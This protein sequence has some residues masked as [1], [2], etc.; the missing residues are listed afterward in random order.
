[1][2]R[3]VALSGL[4]G[5][6]VVVVGLVLGGWL[7]AG[8]VLLVAAGIVVTLVGSWSRLSLNDRLMRIAVV[9][10]LLALA[11]VRAVPR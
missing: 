10:L 3:L 5:L 1:M 4:T 11:L 6:A 8:L 7:G 9:A 2:R